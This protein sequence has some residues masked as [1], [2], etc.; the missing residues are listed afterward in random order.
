MPV[1]QPLSEEKAKTMLDRLDE[2]L[3]SVQEN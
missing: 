3:M 1:L 2:V